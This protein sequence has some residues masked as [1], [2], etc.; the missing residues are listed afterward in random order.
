MAGFS[1][2]G[3]IGAG[4]SEPESVKVRTGDSEAFDSGAWEADLEAGTLEADLVVR[5]LEVVLEAALEAALEAGVLPVVSLEGAVLFC[6]GLEAVLDE[7]LLEA[8]AVE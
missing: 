3:T 4:T 8:C 6:G 7:G 5:I 1:R 2:A